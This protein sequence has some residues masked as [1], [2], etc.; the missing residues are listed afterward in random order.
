MHAGSPAS[1][2]NDPRGIPNARFRLHEHLPERSILFARLAFY[3][4]VACG[5]E[6][7][8][9]RWPARATFSATSERGARKARALLGYT[10]PTGANRSEPPCSCAKRGAVSTRPPVDCS[11][12]TGNPARISR[13]ELSRPEMAMVRK[14]NLAASGKVKIPLAAWRPHAAPV[15]HSEAHY[16]GRNGSV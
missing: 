8:G 14:I 16:R 11:R 4:T 6:R 15:V 2:Q 1:T 7:A 13:L 12:R 5:K 3:N 10:R 9:N